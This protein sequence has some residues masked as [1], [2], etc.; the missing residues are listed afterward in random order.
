MALAKKSYLFSAAL[1]LALALPGISRG[2]V[3]GNCS[4]DAENPPARGQMG[5]VS[6]ITTPEKAV[7]YLNGDK[8]GLSPIDTAYPTGRF[9]L[10]IMLNGEELVKERV[11]VCAGEKTSWEGSLKMPYGS[12][13]VKTNPLKINAV[14][15][16]DGEQVGTTKGGVLTINRLE[17]GTRVFK[18][19]NGRRRKEMSVNVLPEETVDLNVDFKK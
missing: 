7:V 13:A 3:K 5:S 14:V 11:N 10:T 19:T 16:V 17:A 15:Y 2:E 9:S 12:V 8:L 6:I 4:Q 18:I 1:V